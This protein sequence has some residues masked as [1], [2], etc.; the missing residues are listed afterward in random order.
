[1]QPEWNKIRFLSKLLTDMSKWK[2]ERE[3]ERERDLQEA[4]REETISTGFKET[5]VNGQ[6]QLVYGL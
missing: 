1:M 3:R 4:I 6:I 5:A 2:R